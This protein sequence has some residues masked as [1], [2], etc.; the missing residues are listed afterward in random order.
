MKTNG[1]SKFKH[2]RQRFIDGG[3]DVD[4][5]ARER[6]GARGGCIDVDAFG[7]MVKNAMASAVNDDDGNDNGVIVCV[8][9]CVSKRIRQDMI[10]DLTRLD[11][12]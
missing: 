3:R 7:V 9:V 6:F 10:S 1:A 11:A 4:R 2:R 8:C 12:T 5:T